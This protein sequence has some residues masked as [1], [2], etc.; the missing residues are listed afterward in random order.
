MP[1]IIESGMTFGPYPE[2]HCFHIEKSAT[3][4]AI[5]EGVRM[6]EFFLLRR[7]EGKPPVVLVVEAKSSAPRPESN[8]NFGDYISEI[9]EKLVNGLTLG[10]A[11]CLRRHASAAAELPEPFQTLDLTS[12]GFRLVLVINAHKKEWL[13]P[14][15]DAL[16]SALH[17][18]TQ[19]WALGANAVAVINE[20]GA[21]KHG[22]IA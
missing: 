4:A 5:Q 15:Q 9:R 6:G 17:P 12:S 8:P 1:P 3:Y 10:V 13:P 21:R 2:G 20:E 7:Q 18:T 14:L 11:S 16:V 19:T 22:L